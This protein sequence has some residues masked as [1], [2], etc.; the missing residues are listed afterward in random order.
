M[1]GPGQSAWTLLVSTKAYMSASKGHLLIR[2][3]LHGP[4]LRNALE[5]RTCM[6]HKHSLQNKL[7]IVYLAY[8]LSLYLQLTSQSG[9]LHSIR[10]GE[11]PVC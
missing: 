8:C 3:P 1:T 9:E 2:A 5:M 11:I 7:L 4:L 10:N 6:L